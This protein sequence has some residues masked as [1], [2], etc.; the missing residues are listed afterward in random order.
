LGLNDG[1]F[2]SRGVLIILVIDHKRGE[3]VLYCMTFFFKRAAIKVVERYHMLLKGS[4]WQ[5]T[6]YVNMTRIYKRGK[7]RAYVDYTKTAN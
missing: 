1:W 6:Q 7:K 3:K 2:N 5:G 4:H